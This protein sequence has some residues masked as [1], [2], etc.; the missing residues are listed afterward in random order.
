MLHTAWWLTTAP[1]VPF[2]VWVLQSGALEGRADAPLPPAVAGAVAEAALGHSFRSSVPI[3]TDGKDDWEIDSTQL[4][5]H[6]KIASGS[7]GDL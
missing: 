2:G 7:F 5:L 1:P 4:K 6:H 3:P